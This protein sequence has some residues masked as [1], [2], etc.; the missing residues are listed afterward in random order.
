MRNVELPFVIMSGLIDPEWPW[1]PA[2]HPQ[3]CD[4]M[5]L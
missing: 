5:P 2:D 4:R 1:R 3:N